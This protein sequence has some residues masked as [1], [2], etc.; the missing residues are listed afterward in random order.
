M[1]K[2]T[3]VPKHIFEKQCLD[4]YQYANWIDFYETYGNEG[5]YQSKYAFTFRYQAGTSLE[6]AT[7]KK[8]LLEINQHMDNKTMI[9]LIVMVTTKS[10]NGKN[11]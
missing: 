7:K 5:W 4:W 8:N 3:E 2:K 10:Y 9:K 6:Y 1:K 11:W